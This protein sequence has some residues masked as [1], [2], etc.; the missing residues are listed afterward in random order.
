MFSFILINALIFNQRHH[1]LYKYLCLCFKKSVLNWTFCQSLL[2]L[3]KNPIAR[4]YLPVN[5]MGST[6]SLSLSHLEDLGVIMTVIRKI[7]SKRFLQSSKQNQIH[8]LNLL[9]P[10]FTA[11]WIQTL[12]LL[13]V[14]HWV[15]ATF[16]FVYFD[17][18]F[19]L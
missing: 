1:F 7:I 16:T 11:G 12:R 14:Y 3:K 4:K 17:I 2:R 18:A 13:V 10:P 9:L 8:K 15:T 6:H 19:T 5:F